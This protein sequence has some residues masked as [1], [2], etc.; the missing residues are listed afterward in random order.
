MV[1][2]EQPDPTQGALRR[3]GTAAERY[4]SERDRAIEERDSMDDY[5]SMVVHEL[6]GPLGIIRGYADILSTCA[7]DPPDVGQQALSAITVQAE[8][9]LALVG[10]ILTAARVAGRGL[11]ASLQRLDLHSEAEAAIARFA[12]AVRL[13]NAQITLLPAAANAAAQADAKLLELILDNLINNALLYSRGP[14][15]I[16]VEVGPGPV[17]L[18]RDHGKGIP[19]EMFERIFERFLRVQDHTPRP[20]SGLGLYI[21][22]ALAE[23]MGGF[24]RVRESRLEHGTTFE[25]RLSP[26][27]ELQ[28]LAAL[29]QRH[30][31][32]HR[33]RLQ[34]QTE[35]EESG[36]TRLNV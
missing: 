9:A 29:E 33:E 26:A 30:Q 8:A 18:V 28:P 16:E 14:A 22:R 4:R 1:D 7:L 35:D 19:P 12:T 3:N 17:I 36:Q 34:A 31:R 5:I 27:P 6:R 21:A 11:Q 24:L 10:E 32:N 25:L 13:E 23:R 20:G 2:N 15:R